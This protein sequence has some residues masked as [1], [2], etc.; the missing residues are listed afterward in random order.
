MKEL[1]FKKLNNLDEKGYIVLIE[2]IERIEGNR[3]VIIK[4]IPYSLQNYRMKEWFDICHKGFLSVS[5]FPSYAELLIAPSGNYYIKLLNDNKE[6][7]EHALTDIEELYLE[8][9]KSI[10]KK[11]MEEEEC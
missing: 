7:V 8:V 1:Q 2:K 11:D 6:Y 3:C 4:G 5:P 9:A 10:V